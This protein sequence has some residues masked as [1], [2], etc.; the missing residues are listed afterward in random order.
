MQP[1][2][3]VHPPLADPFSRP[4]FHK[5]YD[6]DTCTFTLPGLPDVFGDRISIRLVGIDTPEIRGHCQQEKRLAAQA[7]DFL[8][9]E[10]MQ[11]AVIRQW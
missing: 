1:P 10:L 9:D 6:G 11:A 7:R 4:I 8:N 3:S 2:S 5:C